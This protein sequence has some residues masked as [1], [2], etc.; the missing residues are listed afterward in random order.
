VCLSTEPRWPE[1]GGH[2]LAKI[3]FCDG[4]GSLFGAI[5]SLKAFCS[6]A[7]PDIVID[8][9][10]FT[11]ARTWR[12][13]FWK[14][15]TVNSYFK[16]QCCFSLLQYLCYYILLSVQI[17][18]NAV[19]FKIAPRKHE[20]ILNNFFPI[21]RGPLIIWFLCHWATVMTACSVAHSQKNVIA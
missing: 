3:F 5:L 9:S 12:I 16:Q 15:I 8:W 10:F 21:T 11:Y 13:K 1:G 2:L 17:E 19:I 18:Q 4:F 7:I 14:Y 6:G 20:S